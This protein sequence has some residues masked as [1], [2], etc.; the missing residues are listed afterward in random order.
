MYCNAVCFAKNVS[1]CL[2]K[3]ITD[4]IANHYITNQTPIDKL[5]KH[6]PYHIIF[7]SGGLILNQ[8][9]TDTCNA[10]IF[11]DIEFENHLKTV[12]VF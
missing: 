9:A 4:S 5:L 11:N 1:H 8:H 7:K 3:H 10:I 2:P 6:S 12:N